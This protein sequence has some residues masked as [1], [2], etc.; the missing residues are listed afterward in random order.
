MRVLL[1]SPYGEKLDAALE[2]DD[3][4]HVEEYAEGD[5]NWAEFI[6]SYGHRKIIKPEVIAR[7]PHRIINI[8]ISLLP[9]NRGADP[10]FWSFFDNTPKGVTIHEID[11]GVDTGDIIV[12]RSIHA[13]SSGTLRSTYDNL[14]SNAIELFSNTWPSIR[15]GE[16]RRSRQSR[17]GT[18][19]KKKDIIPW[20]GKL[21]AGW[22]T[23]VEEVEEMGRSIR[24]GKCRPDSPP[25]RNTGC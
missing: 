16:A 25:I 7:F 24:S 10:N 9:W 22:D 6:I 11:C 20:F 2:G 4:L 19:H 3:V 14:H 17:I 23:P 12:A 8:H 13:A 1:L 18:V 15:S 21:S 5:L